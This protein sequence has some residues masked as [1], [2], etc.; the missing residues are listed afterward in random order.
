MSS[1]DNDR[2][3]NQPH[4]DGMDIDLTGSSS[5]LRGYAKIVTEAMTFTHPKDNINDLPPFTVRH[6]DDWKTWLKMLPTFSLPWVKR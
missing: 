1:L 6:T 5:Q 2:I 3:V 4:D